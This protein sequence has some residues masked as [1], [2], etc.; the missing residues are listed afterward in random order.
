MESETKSP[1][2]VFNILN[3]YLNIKNLQNLGIISKY[4]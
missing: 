2:S 3:N 1:I 4:N